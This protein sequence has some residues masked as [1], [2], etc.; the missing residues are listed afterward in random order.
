MYKMT[1]DDN[2]TSGIIPDF[3]K[4]EFNKPLSRFAMSVAMLRLCLGPIKDLREAPIED[5]RRFEEDLLVKGR[6]YFDYTPGANPDRTYGPEVLTTVEEWVRALKFN[7]EGVDA[8]P[9]S[10]EPREP[11]FLI[12]KEPHEL[13]IDK[14]PAFTETYGARTGVERP[15][16]GK[17]DKVP[18]GLQREIDRLLAELRIGGERLIEGLKEGRIPIPQ[19]GTVED[20]L[21]A[22]DIA[23]RPDGFYIS[24]QLIPERP[25]FDKNF[26]QLPDRRE[27]D[28]Y[29]IFSQLKEKK[30]GEY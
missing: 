4:N 5:R 9:R 23:C 14:N 12:K 7:T 21:P 17:S 25:Y 19:E 29:K 16:W 6:E 22:D 10:V 30:K 27:K 18:E 13:F 26:S 8:P 20:R 1:D 3:L 28:P 2:K 15:Y 11:H 24:E